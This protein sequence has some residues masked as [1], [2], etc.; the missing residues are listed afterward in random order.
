MRWERSHGICLAVMVHQ[1]RVWG[2]ATVSGVGTVSCNQR[3][4]VCE[5][6]NH[7]PGGGCPDR[8][9]SVLRTTGCSSSGACNAL[10]DRA[11]AEAEPRPCAIPVQQRQAYAEAVGM[12][13]SPVADKGATR[14][15]DGAAAQG[16]CG[17]KFRIPRTGCHSICG[18]LLR[19]R[20]Q[21][22]QRT[23]SEV[24]GQVAVRPRHLERIRAASVAR[25]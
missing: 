4:E 19:V 13:R 7:H 2:C 9:G 8:G 24:S 21:P 14:D 3:R 11:V 25:S 23:Q 20:R 22:V 15:R 17:A 6:H 18:G 10:A 16:G 12:P 1:S 5:V